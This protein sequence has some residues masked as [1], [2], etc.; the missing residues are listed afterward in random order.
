MSIAQLAV[1][2]IA[3]AA[4]EEIE[5]AR[6]AD[7]EDLEG[8]DPEAVADEIERLVSALRGMERTRKM[9]RDLITALKN[10]ECR[11]GEDELV[12]E[13][14]AWAGE[15]APEDCTPKEPEA[16]PREWLVPVLVHDN[17]CYRGTALVTAPTAARAR[18]RFDDD[19]WAFEV[20]GLKLVENEDTS[21]EADEDR[22]V[23]PVEGCPWEP[24]A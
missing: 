24:K 7:V 11:A 3:Q 6:G 13:A 4:D 23:E 16:E 2:M 17:A 21:R 10:S 18:E 9:V 12:A 5:F 8:H 19:P 15:A 1:A 20:D 14:Q 22:E